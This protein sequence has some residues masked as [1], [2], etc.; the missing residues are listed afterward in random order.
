MEMHRGCAATMSSRRREAM[1][2][3]AIRRHSMPGLMPAAVLAGVLA[4]AA[5]GWLVLIQRMAGMDTGPGGDPGTLSWFVVTW[6]VMTAAMMP[7]ASAPAA[8]SLAHAWR[9]RTPAAVVLF[10]CGYVA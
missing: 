1:A 3:L 2:Q 6:A 8:V 7:P 4:T 9:T 5:A 10:L